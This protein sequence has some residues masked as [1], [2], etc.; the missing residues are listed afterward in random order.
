MVGIA[1]QKQSG[2]PGEVG[3][4]CDEHQIV[5]LGLEAFDPDRRIVVGS[6]G[7]GLLDVGVKQSTPD[8]GRLT[9]P[10]LAR[11]NHPSRPRTELHDGV[12]GH[13]NNVVDALVGERP[14]RVLGLG[15][16]LPMLNEVE[17]HPH[18]GRARASPD[19]PK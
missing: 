6:Q 16:G 5:R 8:L 4:M 19:E 9:G 14:V 18:Q 10:R 7:I 1:R 13:P 17:L 11:M 2:E 3:K 12:M 15:L